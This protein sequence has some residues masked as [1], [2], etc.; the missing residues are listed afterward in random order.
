MLNIQNYTKRFGD[1]IAVD[2]LSLHIAAGEICAF[3][4][5]NGAGKTT[6]LKACCGLLKP[7]GGT[8]TVNGIDIQKDPIACKKIM[9]YIP[10]NPDLYEFL[11]GYEYLN[12][13]ADMYGVS[14]ADRKARMEALA[15][16]L[17]IKNA[18]P[19]LISEC[20]HGMK[21]KIAV[22]GALIHE[23]KLILMDE[24]FVGLDPIAAHELPKRRRYLLF[25]TRFG[26]GGEAVR[27]CGHYQK[28]QAHCTRHHGQRARRRFFG[29]GLLRAGRPQGLKGGG[30][31]LRS[32]WKLQWKQFAARMK[33]GNG[34]KTSGGWLVFLMLFFVVCMEILM[35]V[36]FAEL[37]PL[38]EMGL[39]WLYFAMAGTAALALSMLGSV[40]MTQAQLYDVKD[41]ERLLSMPI[42]PKYI[43]LTR[44]AM[45]FTTTAGYTLAVLLPA[46]GIYAFSYGASATMIIG[47]LFTFVALSL[48]SQSVCCALGWVLHKLLSR[49]R[50]KAVVSLLYMVIF[51]AVYWYFY[52]NVNSFLSG[53]VMQGTQIAGAMK[54]V[55]LLYAIGMACGGSLLH[56]LLV[57][58]LSA[59]IA[60]FTLWRLSASF[61]S[62]VR[63]SGA[64]AGAKHKSGKASA[65]Q[66]TPVLS[67]A[68]KEQR[69][70]F[71]SPA[72]LMNFGFGLVIIPV[73]PIAAAIFRGKLMQMISLMGF[74]PE[75][76]ALG[77]FGVMAFCIATS[78]ATAPSVSLEGKN[79]WVLRTMPISGKTVLLGKLLMVCRLQM[80]L[81]AVSVL[82][83][84]LIAGCG[85]GLTVL[86]V[87]VCV[88]FCWFVG[89]LGL[90]MNL[91]A[92]RFDWQS[93]NQPC[94]QSLSVCVTMFGA[95]FFA[96]VIVGVFFAVSALHIPGIA[97]YAV[98]TAFLL[99]ASV[100]M[101]LLLVHWGAK[102]FERLEA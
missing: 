58:L 45:L 82:A 87:C 11:T 38:C 64:K 93:E 70:F 29:A 13:V 66:R 60:L 63:T 18:L 49:L 30:C 26:S 39:T 52:A 8:I 65:K 61:I 47:W 68:H 37:V 9:A 44:I 51:M 24:P 21:Q 57:T 73:L 48:I 59:A 14:E 42:P 71:T 23:P 41:N 22:I 72:Y 16:R 101:H 62:S 46:F 5:H 19:N 100:L 12:F 2:D 34:K 90:V 31:M 43:L 92:P 10:D 91:L 54:Y 85:I 79:L 36:V 98:T 69:K 78:C 75:W 97:A 28:R 35:F 40:F 83:L 4:G 96:A 74:R 27:Q 84:C 15:E 25:H 88:L 1:K 81:V 99:L 102:K 80:P 32:L 76:I 6:T 7:D 33:K 53:L 20:S 17:D 77:I 55:W 67:V 50:N 95:Y 89:T 56:T 94:K 86:T 3:I